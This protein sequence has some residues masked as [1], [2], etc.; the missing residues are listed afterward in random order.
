VH[1]AARHRQR[2]P[3][4]FLRKAQARACPERPVGTR[5]FLSLG[6]L[7]GRAGDGAGRAAFAKV[8]LVPGRA[9]WQGRRDR[10]HLLGAKV[11]Q[12]EQGST[13]CY[14]VRCLLGRAAVVT[15]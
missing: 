7:R 11:T 6:V 5:L 9:C 14:V 2:P 4:S 13:P 15:P 12:C 8:L 3:C 1:N 10:V